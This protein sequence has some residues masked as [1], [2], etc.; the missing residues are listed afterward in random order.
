M[1]LTPSTIAVDTRLSQGARNSFPKQNTHWWG[2]NKPRK[3]KRR[4]WFSGRQVEG[5]L[6]F[7]G[8]YLKSTQKNIQKIPQSLG[9]SWAFWIGAQQSYL[10]LESWGWNFVVAV[11]DQAFS[12]LGTHCIPKRWSFFHTCSLLATPPQKNTWNPQKMKV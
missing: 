5:N 2:K 3:R 1:P 7:S 10:T 9:R 4:Y 8:M 6:S 11:L 12:P